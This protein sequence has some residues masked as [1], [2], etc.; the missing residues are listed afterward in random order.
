M[1]LLTVENLVTRFDTEAGAVHAVQGISYSVAPGEAVAIVGESGSGKTVGALSLLGLVPAPGRVVDGSIRLGDRDLTLLDDREWASVRGR[2]I[3]MVF[4]DPMTSLNPVLTV[5][6]QITEALELHLGLTGKDARARAVTLL[7]RVGIPDAEGRFTSYPHELSGGQRQRVMIAMAISCEPE[8][9]IADEPTTALD[10]TIQAQIVELIRG[11][12]AESGMAI[13]WITHD[14]ALASTLVDRVLVMYAGRI[15]EDAPV[16]D[17]FQAPRH[18]YT[19]GLLGS[20][21]LLSGIPGSKLRSIA[22]SPPSLASA[23]P[24]CAFAPRCTFALE[25]CRAMTP[26]VR[27]TTPAHRVACLRSGEAEL[28]QAWEATGPPDVHKPETRS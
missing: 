24:G 15:V 5:G 25:T 6:R 13:I 28:Q 3:A 8:V 1:S 2:R 11:L 14:L 26:P 23:R 19:M 17:I 22:G 4:Q 10:V 7:D 16:A 20:M 9:L 27:G 18:P 21:P 12:Q